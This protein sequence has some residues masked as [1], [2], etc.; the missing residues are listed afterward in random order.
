MEEGA[1]NKLI[2]LKGRRT[3]RT[4]APLNTLPSL[5][6]LPIKLLSRYYRDNEYLGVL[7]I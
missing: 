4:I 6:I 5:V 3:P 7:M 1:I 2:G